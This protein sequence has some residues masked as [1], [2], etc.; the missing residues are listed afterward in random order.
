MDAVRYDHLS[1]Y[2][3]QRS[4]TPIVDSIAEQGVRFDQVITPGA[5]TWES[6]CSFFTGRYPQHHGVRYMGGAPLSGKIPV[7]AEILKNY[8][9]A[10]F[11]RTVDLTAAG[12]DRGYQD[13]DPEWNREHSGIHRYRTINR[14]LNKVFPHRSISGESA[15]YDSAN[16]Q[17]LI[18]WAQRQRGNNWFGLIRYLTAH[19]PYSPPP[20]FATM[21]AS[22]F[23]GDHSFNDYAKREDIVAGRGFSANQIQ[24]AITHY[25]R[26]IRFIDAEIGKL[27]ESL[28][29]EG[30]FDDTLIVVMSDHGEG[31]GEHGYY[32]E[33]GDHV[34]EH[35][36]RVPLVICGPGLASG[37]VVTNPV[38][39]IDLFPTILELLQVPC[40]S[41]VDGVTLLPLINGKTTGREYT[42]SESGRDFHHH[43][44]RFLDRVDGAIRTV[45][46][47]DGW[48]LVYTPRHIAHEFKLYFLPQDPGEEQDLALTNPDVLAE[49]QEELRCWI[50][51]RDCKSSFAS[52]DFRV[53]LQVEDRLRQLG[54]IE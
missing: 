9:F 20:P 51:D 5:R 42:F 50:E 29:Q 16:S 40:P 6:F 36:I 14:I 12:L 31:L 35:L 30:Q 37:K 53:Q 52:E 47:R 22:R 19:W 25:D 2:G 46:R 24:H 17:A 26:A 44:E 11:G 27:I 4:T 23:D 18:R 41:P 33:H 1:C 7:L 45:R 21:F 13:F 39:T 49:L 3:Y 8:G 32:F 54:Y 38:Q 48:K 34:Y 15:A 28:K 43:S 10:T